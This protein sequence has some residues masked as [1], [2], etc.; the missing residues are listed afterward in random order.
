MAERPYGNE[1]RRRKVAPQNNRCLF[2]PS[3]WSR[4]VIGAFPIIKT[5]LL[6]SFIGEDYLQCS[7]VCMKKGRIP[8]LCKVLLRMIY[9]TV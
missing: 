9:K 8:S 7:A 6:T 5:I 4:A 3:N 1:Q 2:I